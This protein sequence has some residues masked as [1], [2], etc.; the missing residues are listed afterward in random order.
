M[1]SKSCNINI[2]GLDVASFFFDYANEIEYLIFRQRN[3]RLK[4]SSGCCGICHEHVL[5]GLLVRNT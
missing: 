5:K 4:Y 1:R 2:T 3:P